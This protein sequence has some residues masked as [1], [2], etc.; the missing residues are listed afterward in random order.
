MRTPPVEKWSC[1]TPARCACARPAH[2]PRR[3]PRPHRDPRRYSRRQRDRN[4]ARAPA[5]RDRT[6]RPGGRARTL[7][8]TEGCRWRL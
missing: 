5:T 8:P 6:D 3:P 7:A 1:C 4:S 2:R